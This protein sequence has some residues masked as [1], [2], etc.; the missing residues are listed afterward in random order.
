MHGPAA[1]PK[2]VRHKAC[3]SC[4]K[5]RA[6]CDNARPCAQCVLRK[7]GDACEDPERKS[8]CTMCRRLRAKCDKE[9]PCGRCVE[10][11]QAAACSSVADMMSQSR[12]RGRSRASVLFALAG[13]GPSAGVVLAAPSHDG[14]GAMP[15]TAVHLG[16]CAGIFDGWR[17]ETPAKDEIEP[18]EAAP[19]SAGLTG[20][21]LKSLLQHDDVTPLESLLQ[22]TASIEANL[23]C[24]RIGEDTNSEAADSAASTCSIDGWETWD[25]LELGQDSMLDL[26]AFGEAF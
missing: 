14:P 21:L 7:L 9:R 6:K 8:S 20:A 2:A 25:A 24:A 19:P 11:R 13:D 23:P 16:S 3:I 26:T 4:A 15:A 12:H 5:L 18:A 22:S 17:T 10:S 1:R